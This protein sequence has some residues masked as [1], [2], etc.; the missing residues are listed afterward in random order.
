M[1]TASRK[2]VLIAPQHWGLG[3]VTRTI[4]VIRYFIRKGY[5]LVL[6]SSGAGSNLLRKEFPELVV[7]DVP[8]Y[9]ITYP[10]R[11][12]F[13]NMTFQIF[14]LHKAILLEKIALGKICKEHQIDLVVSNARL[15][16][17]QNG[18]ASVIISHHLHIPLG[19]KLIEFISDT[20]MRFFYL[21]FNQIWVPDFGGDHNLSGDLAHQFKSSKHFF[22]GPLSRF[23]TMDL[24]QRFDICFMLSGPEPQRRFF[25]E[26]ILS[27]INDLGPAKMIL[28]RGTTTGAVLPKYVNLEVKDLVTSEELNEI[29]C[30]SGLIVCR[31]GYSTLLDL[32]VIQKK[33]LLIPTPGQPEQEYLGRGLMAKNLFLNVDQDDLNLKKH[34]KEALAYPGY[35]EFQPS[36]GLEYYL[37]PLIQ[38]MLPE[39]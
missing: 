6:A 30:S 33:A 5:E 15:G 3:H 25:E 28:I 27:Q 35:L 23:R 4:P 21:Q 8:D 17:A 14:K 37:D 18:I 13:W 20:W 10:S 7:Y 31:S 38:K 26:K 22:I 24:P 12:M 39:Q 34:V 16:A 11:N 36:S 2:K 1:P 32:S 29:M 19:S 9:G